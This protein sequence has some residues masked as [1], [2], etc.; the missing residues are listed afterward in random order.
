VRRRRVAGLGEVDFAN[1]SNP[2]VLVPHRPPPDP[3][4]SQQMVGP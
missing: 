1:T 3:T 2:V 4:G